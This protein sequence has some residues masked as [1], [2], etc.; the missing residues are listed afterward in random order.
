MAIGKTPIGASAAGATKGDGKSYWS[1][2][3]TNLILNGL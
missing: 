2:W 3:S 1:S